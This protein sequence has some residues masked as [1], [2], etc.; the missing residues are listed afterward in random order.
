MNGDLLRFAS[1][2]HRPLRIGAAREDPPGE[3]DDDGPTRPGHAEG[4]IAMPAL[5]STSTV[6]M[7]LV[8]HDLTSRV[9]G[10]PPAVATPFGVALT[11]APG[12]FAPGQQVMAP[13]IDECTAPAA[14]EVIATGT[15]EDRPGIWCLV[16]HRGERWPSALIE[17]WALRPSAVVTGGGP[18]R[19]A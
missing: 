1:Q 4:S 17:E 10:R 15:R 2:S 8:L 12:R 13:G 6:P 19:L 14:A 11:P 5:Q 3:T 9:S 7:D 18:Y 16:R